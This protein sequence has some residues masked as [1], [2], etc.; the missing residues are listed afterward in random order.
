MI[1]VPDPDQPYG[2]NLLKGVYPDC[3]S[4][5]VSGTREALKKL[6][7]D[8]QCV[9]MD[10]VLRNTLY[11]LIE[12]GGFVLPDILSMHTGQDFRR[13]VLPRIENEQLLGFW[14]R[15]FTVYK[16]HYHQD[17]IAPIQ[18]RTGAFLVDP[19][20]RRIFSSPPENLSFS[21]NMDNSRILIVNVSKGRL[22]EEAPISL[23]RSS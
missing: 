5:A 21:S 20:L 17:M 18:N 6:S 11:A 19:K 14:K 23:A 7:D 12:A 10:H 1:K 16:P 22:V 9:R 2:H 4:L 8:A 3:A 15:G 13:I